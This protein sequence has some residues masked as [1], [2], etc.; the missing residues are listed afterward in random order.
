M[1]RFKTRRQAD[2]ARPKPASGMLDL[3]LSE[4]RPG[5]SDPAA[6]AAWCAARRR[7]DALT[8]CTEF[9]PRSALGLTAAERSKWLARRRA[10]L[11]RVL[12]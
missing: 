11:A 8:V 4:R 3:A 10:H 9:D 7:I 12:V 2:S 6:D 5:P 1:A